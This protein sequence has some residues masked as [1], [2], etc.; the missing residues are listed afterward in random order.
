MIINFRRNFWDVQRKKNKKKSVVDEEETGEE[1]VSR[2]YHKLRESFVR[3]SIGGYLVVDGKFWEISD[4][5][6]IFV[7][8]DIGASPG[9]MTQYLSNL[10]SEKVSIDSTIYQN[11]YQNLHSCLKINKK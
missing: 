1:I 6:E 2:A 7:G 3:F 4:V 8:V 10:L 5:P 11:N 9:G